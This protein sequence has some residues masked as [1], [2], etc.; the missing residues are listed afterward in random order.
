LGIISNIVIAAM[1]FFMSQLTMGQTSNFFYGFENAPGA[2]DW[3]ANIAVASGTNGITA[4]NGSSYGSVPSPAS[5]IQFTRFGSYNSIWPC[6]GYKTSIKI[7]LDVDGGYANDTRL[8]Y[9]SAINKQDGTHRRD[10]LFAI[11]FYNDGVS[12]GTGNRF[13]VSASNNAPGWPKDPSRSP[14]V[15]AT[16]SGWYTFEHSFENNAGVLQVVMNVYDENN[17]LTGTWTLS[18]P[19]DLIE[20]IVGGNRYGWIVN[21]GFSPLAVDDVTLTLNPGNLPTSFTDFE[22]FANGTVNYKGPGCT[23]PWNTYTIP[24]PYGSLWTT[25]DEWGQSAG[26]WDQEV[27][28]DGGNKV[29]RISNAVTSSGFSNQPYSPSSLLV[30]GET[31]AALYNY[32]GTNHTTPVAPPGAR[33]TASSKYFHGG[34]KFKSATG[35]A[36]PGLT[37]AINPA[38]RQGN[39]RMS[40]VG[41]TDNGSTGFNLNFFETYTGGTFSPSIP[42]ASGLS[43]TAWHELNI[44]I[45][46]VDGLNGDGSGNDIVIVELNGNVIH[47]G[48][49][50]ETYYASAA[51]TSTPDPIAVDALMFRLSGT[52]FPANSGNGFYVDDV[53]YDNVTPPAIPVRA[54]V[55]ADDGETMLLSSHFFIQDAINA[56]SNGNFIR[57][58]PD[59][60]PEILT[61]N[62][63]LTIRG[64]NAGTAG[65]GMRNAEAII[66]DGKVNILGNNTVVF[67]GFKIYQTN[68]TTPVSLGGGAVATIQNNIIERFGVATGST[69]RGI[70]ISPGAGAKT[71][72]NNLITGD[73]S[74]GLFG[75]HKTWNN[76]IFMNG[77]PGN[78]IS[79]TGNVFQNCRTALSIDDMVAGIS[80]SGN[81]FKNSGTYIGFGGTSPSTGSYVFGANEFNT[82]IPTGT[83]INLSNVSTTFRLDISAGTYGSTPFP[84]LS[85]NALFDLSARTAH[86][87]RP[88]GTAPFVSNGLV[89]YKPNNLYVINLPVIPFADD[90]NIAIGLASSGNTINIQDGTYNQRLVIDKSIT[91]DGQSEAGTILN[92]TGLVGTGRGITINNAV[93]NVTIQDLTVQNFSGAGPNTFAGI[94]A[95]GG[96]NN[97]TVQNATLKDNLGGSG[98]YANGPVTDIILDNLDVSGHSNVAGAARGIVIWNGLKSNI[99]ITNCDVYNNNCCGIELQDGTASGVTMTDNNVYNNSD[100]GIG[101]VGLQ[102]PGENLISENMLTNNGRFGIE[103]KNPNGSGLATGAGRIVVENNNVSRNIA[104]VDLRDIAGIS[105]FRRGVLAGNVDVPNGV[106]VQN[107]TVTGYLQTL[108]EEGFGIVIEG[109][110]HTVTGNTV[111]NCNIGLQLQGGVHPNSFYPDINGPYGDGVGNGAQGVGL[112]PSYFGRGNSPITCGITVSGNTISGNG[113]DE[114]N[115]P[116]SLATAGVVVNTNTSK[117]FCSIQA[118]IDDALTEIGHI[119]TVAAGTYTE[120]VTVSKPVII[121]GAN[122][123]VSACGTRSAESIIQNGAFII[124]SDGV[125]IDGFE[126]T[127]TGAQIRAGV[128]VLSDIYILN[129]HI[130]ATNAQPIQHGL[131]FGGGIGSSNWTISGNKIADIQFNAATAIVAFNISN[132][133]IENNCIAHTNASFTGR[134]GINADGLQNANISGNTLDLGDVYPTGGT[135]TPWGIQIGMSDRDATAITLTGNTIMN[136]DL[137]IFSLSQRNLTGFNATCNVL[138]GVRLGFI[139]NSGGVTPQV[140]MPLQ[141]NITLQ[142]NEVT[143]SNRCVFFRNIHNADSNG[144][145]KFNNLSVE[146]NILIRTTAGAAID[147]DPTNAGG[148]IINDGQVKAEK[149]WYGSAIYSEV[150]ARNLGAIDFVPYQVNGTDLDLLTSCFDPDPVASIGGPVQVYDGNTFIAVYTTIQAAIDN[151]TTLSGHTVRI[152]SGTYVENVDA[153]TG[154]KSLIFAPGASPGCVTINGN[155]TLNAG[156][157]L[158]IEF[159]GTNPCTEH[160]K[161][162]VNG[163]VTL[164]DATLNVTLGYTPDIGDAITIIENDLADDVSGIFEQ[165]YSMLIGGNLYSISYTDGG[166]DVVLTRCSG[167]VVNISAMPNKEFCSIQDAIDDPT[168]LAGHTITVA[169]GTYNESVYIWKDNITILGPNAG[170]AGNGTRPNP[171]AIVNTTEWYGIYTDAAGV[172]IDGITLDGNTTCDYGIYAYINNTGKGNH[173]IQ[174]NIVKNINIMG[175]VGWVQAGTPSSNNLVTHN[176][177]HDIDERAIVALWNYYADVTENVIHSTP[178]GIY[179]ENANQPESPAM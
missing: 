45:E 144:P 56:A 104:I 129:N 108:P 12:P 95:V 173:T 122:A 43:Y 97:L 109:T 136:T 145:V 168:T 112:S 18:D 134:R 132:A 85:L 135:N 178:I 35:A 98:F 39:V 58:E 53:E 46:F 172:T 10:F 69:V 82:T 65:N 4:A 22:S 83:L 37:M 158:D 103:I 165:G 117:T 99:T 79:I 33:Y 139:F 61:I 42:I 116:A 70:E 123:G 93:T 32:R 130:H 167:G 48:T 119:L 163:T 49:T 143:S 133:S 40:F 153:V 74:G 121:R 155:L 90:I 68:T 63:D 73:V 149:N 86:M 170:T 55:Y 7:Y 41:I 67:D 25:G 159:N 52:A 24:S 171:E 110:N 148:A 164:G 88:K 91:L 2:N 3:S 11:G 105:V 124:T 175:F 107:N 59:T 36:Q 131:G 94:Y 21:N 80:V 20:T 127:G 176:L 137:G 81:T 146:E 114:R 156:D 38:P 169:S 157:V 115:V 6:N 9:T 5:P 15:V 100:N 125:T 150:L 54:R 8:D 51:W 60:Y 76:G 28:S 26:S 142:N 151:V 87:G 17:I 50:W 162:I 111:N 92:G 34:F 64:P 102:G 27:K 14:Q 106:V 166:N 147:T 128:S 154:G 30:A 152:A 78:S 72:A 118:A 89:T 84:S 77:T 120:T 23:V 57:V 113:V 179:T 29:W 126:L 96:N 160:D 66:S 19:S 138:S 161:F 71:I 13:V 31:G 44:Y 141:S 1:L 101:I 75:G 177:F 47:V 174:N 62:K 16:T 140:S